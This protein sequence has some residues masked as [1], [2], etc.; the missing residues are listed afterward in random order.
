M[1]NDDDIRRVIGIARDSGVELAIRGGGHSISGHV[2]VRRRIV[3]DLRDMKTLEIDSERSDGRGR[4]RVDG[5]R[6][7]HGGQRRGARD[8]IR[9]Y[10]VGRVSTG[11]TLGGG[12]GYLVRKHGLT[13]DNLLG[14]EIVT[15]D[16]EVPHRR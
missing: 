9:R 4:A 10:R 3:L 11:I 13:V 1:A 16:G 12:V 6:V 15:A 5:G 14:A 2:L 8:G 7:H